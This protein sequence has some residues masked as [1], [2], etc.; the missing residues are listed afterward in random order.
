MTPHLRDRLKWLAGFWALGCVTDVLVVI[1]YRS[2]SSGLI[3]LAMVVS[4]LVT[5]VPFLVTWK[6]V[7]A[8]CPELFFAYALGASAGTLLGMMIKL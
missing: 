8:R 6:G 7:E 1:W 5:L 4:F 2:V 3:P